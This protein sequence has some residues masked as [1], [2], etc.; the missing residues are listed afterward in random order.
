VPNPV[1]GQ[2][3]LL[4]VIL[5]DESGATQR[6]IRAH[7]ARHLEDFTQ[8]KFVDIVADLPRTYNVIRASPSDIDSH[9][10]TN[11]ELPVK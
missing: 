6:D 5:Q 4:A 2:A 7:C 11:G 9:S 3:V 8:P 1:L 10:W